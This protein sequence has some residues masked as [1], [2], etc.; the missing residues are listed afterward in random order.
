VTSNIT[1]VARMA[2]ETGAGAAQVL[3]ASGELAHQAE[4][5]RTQINNFLA[6]IRAA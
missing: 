4:N 6:H 1:G 5:L 3:S 2:E